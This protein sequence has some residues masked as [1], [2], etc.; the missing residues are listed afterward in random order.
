MQSFLI[1]GGGIGFIFVMTCL[2]AATVFIFRKSRP[3]QFQKIFLGFAAG[4]MI[5]ASIWSFLA[6]LFIR[7]CRA[8]FRYPGCTSCC[9]DCAGHAVAVVLRGGSHDLCS[10]GGADSRSESG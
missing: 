7:R 3:G 4:V 6:W 10:D 2:G 8:G 9:V 1:T 5:A